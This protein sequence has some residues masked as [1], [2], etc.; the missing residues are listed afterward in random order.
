MGQV[1]ATLVWIVESGLHHADVSDQIPFNVLRDGPADVSSDPPID[2]SR[3]L[4]RV[5]PKG[6]PSEHHKPTPSLYLFLDPRKSLFKAGKQKLF[7][8]DL[9]DRYSFTLDYPHRP[10]NFYDFVRSEHAYPRL[11]ID[12]VRT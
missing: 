12:E 11:I 8:I 10:L 6:Q 7:S 2:Q 5:T 1:T 3:L 4:Q 9:F